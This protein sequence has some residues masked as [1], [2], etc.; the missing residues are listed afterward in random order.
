MIIDYS[1]DGE[2]F[3]SIELQ[4]KGFILHENDYRKNF[5]I[6]DQSGE[7]TEEYNFVLNFV[8]FLVN[9]EN[10]VFSVFP[11]NFVVNDLNKDSNKLF[12]VISK[13][14]QKRPD[15]YFGSEY[16]KRF[17]SN[18][19]FASFFG[20]YEYYV[21]YGLHFEDKKYI[22]PNTGG[23]VNWKDTIRLSNK[24]V[25]NNHISIFPIYYEKKYYFSAFLTE[26]MIFSINYT[27]EKFNFLIDIDKIERDYSLLPFFN[28]KGMILDQLYALRQE[29][30]KDSLLDLIDHLI[31][32]FSELHEGG[33]Y[34]LKH[35]TF[36]S[37]WEDMVMDYLRLYFQEVKDNKIVFGSKRTNEINFL[38][39][40][41]KPNLANKTHYFSPDYY[42]AEKD[43]Q[44][45]FDAKYYSKIRGMD[46]KQISYFVFLNEY[47]DDLCK[48]IKY[49][50]TY[51]APS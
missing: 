1:R 4:E 14:L 10:N 13:H 31:N 46:Y 21:K 48:P 11:K 44:M 5:I 38:K 37:I 8:G 36:S 30:F 18:F 22:K 47:R 24:F 26:C 12:K 25:S 15:L 27:I 45:I 40:T 9:D 32:F 49:S 19:P 6:D 16:G 23:K 39:P 35:Y 50:T 51:S 7:I 29:T 41:F 28:E 20:I 33:I 17:K 2:E 34:Y 43:I 3:N 42:Y